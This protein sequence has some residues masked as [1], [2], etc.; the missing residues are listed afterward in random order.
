[1]STL[2]IKVL[3]L[4]AIS[5]YQVKSNVTSTSSTIKSTSSVATPVTSDKDK[6]NL[7]ENEEKLTLPTPSPIFHLQQN[8]LYPLASPDNNS[9][10]RR[11]LARKASE[12]FRFN[13]KVDVIRQLKNSSK[14]NGKAQELILL[15]SDLSKL[16]KDNIEKEEVT[17]RT[18]VYNPFGS[19][20][21]VVSIYRGGLSPV[22]PDRPSFDSRYNPFNNR[23]GRSDDLDAFT[24][25][26][27]NRFSTIFGS[28]I[29]F[30][31]TVGQVRKQTIN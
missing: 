12:I 19:D 29:V 25:R 1:M 6:S 18:R 8:S 27:A 3:L 22:D 5:I 20:N 17:E 26:K 13:G 11:E 16:K 2:L 4:G 15:K 14:E 24:A 7:I 21:D 28:K 9:T 30:Q 31:E 23:D 10:D